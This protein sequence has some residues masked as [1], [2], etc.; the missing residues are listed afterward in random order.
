[1]V[2]VGVVRQIHVNRAGAAL[3]HANNDVGRQANF[4]VLVVRYFRVQLVG[5]DAKRVALA[6]V[7][8]IVPVDRTVH[9]I[10]RLGEEI[11]PEEHRP[12][13]DESPELGP[14]RRDRRLD[15]A[16]RRDTRIGKSHCFHGIAARR[17]DVFRTLWATRACR[18]LGAFLLRRG[19]ARRTRR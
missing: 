17:L 2:D 6:V 11:V 8:Q 5:S 7:I 1:M 16:L 14:I 18:T 3:E 19:F 12:V 10:P 13:L 9:D 15:T 4:L